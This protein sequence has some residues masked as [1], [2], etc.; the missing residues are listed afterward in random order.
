MYSVKASDIAKFLNAKLIGKDILV[1]SVSP[2]SMLKK[3]ALLL[4]KKLLILRAILQ[5]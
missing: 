1:T 4:Q 2:I 3:I 5:S